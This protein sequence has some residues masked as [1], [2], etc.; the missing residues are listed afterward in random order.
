MLGS[1]SKNSETQKC[2]LLCGLHKELFQMS[3]LN[4]FDSVL[5]V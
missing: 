3:F 2:H 5:I 1:N 4:G